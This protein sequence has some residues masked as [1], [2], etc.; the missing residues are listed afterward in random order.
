MTLVL[1]AWDSGCTILVTVMVIVFFLWF[2]IV[3]GN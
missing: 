1:A 2:L 3:A